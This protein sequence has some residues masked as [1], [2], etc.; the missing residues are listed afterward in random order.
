LLSVLLCT[1]LLLTP[2]H[3]CV[4]SLALFLTGTEIRIHTEERLL[5]SRFPVEFAE[6]RHRVPAYLPFVR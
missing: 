3:W 2:W 4:V 5:S 1:L 6:Y